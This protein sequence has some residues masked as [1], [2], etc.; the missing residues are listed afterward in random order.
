MKK[1]NPIKKR[2]NSLLVTTLCL[3]K[4]ADTWVSRYNYVLNNLYCLILTSAY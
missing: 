1:S 2:A 3:L 4:L